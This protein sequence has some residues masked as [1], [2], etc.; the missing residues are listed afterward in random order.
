M[1]I[2][3]E[4]SFN[5]KLYRCPA[6]GTFTLRDT[7]HRLEPFFRNG[8]CFAE[9]FGGSAI[10]KIAVKTRLEM[11]RTTRLDTRLWPAASLSGPTELDANRK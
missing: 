11:K 2:D 6:T 10:A 4:L 3:E 8:L 7:R 1:I 5:E 9:E